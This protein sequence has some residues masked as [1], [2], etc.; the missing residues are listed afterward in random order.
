MTLADILIYLC[1]RYPHPQE[2][3]K[4]RLTKMV[5]LADWE[6]CLRTGAQLTGIRWYFHNFGP[7]V[8]DVI[9]A[10][11]GSPYLD[12]I[13]GENLYGEAKQT[14]RLSPFAIAPNIDRVTQ[15]ILDHV[16]AKTRNL[17]WPEFIKHVYSTPPIAESTRYSQLDLVRFARQGR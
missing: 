3:S 12:V 4:A 11:Q 16:I 14:I 10:A 15:N 13:E 7:Y 5:Y 17:Y 6:A 2:L 1:A 9:A 8:D